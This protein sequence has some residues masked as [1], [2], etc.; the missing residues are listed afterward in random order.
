[1]STDFSVDD[2]LTLL[3]NTID[4]FWTQFAGYISFT[5]KELLYY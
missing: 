3:E 5:L 4:Y 1:M 2:R